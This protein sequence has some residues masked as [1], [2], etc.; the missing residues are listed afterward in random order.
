MAMEIDNSKTSTQIQ[1]A[2]YLHNLQQ[3]HQQELETILRALEKLTNLPTERV[4]AYFKM[5]LEHLVQPEET[6][7]FLNQRSRAFYEW[8]ESHREMD[9]PVLS[10]R[11]ISR[12]SIYGEEP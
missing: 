8:V 3:E 7:R 9:L 5:L 2:A 6:P 1:A 10:D 11:A 4:E 12:E